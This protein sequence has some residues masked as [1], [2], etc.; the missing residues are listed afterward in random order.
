MVER[1]DFLKEPI[2]KFFRLFVGNEVRLKGA[3]IIKCTSFD[4]DENGN[5]TAIYATYDKDTKSGTEGA[6]RKVK[7]TI[8]FVNP[9]HA[10]KLPVAFLRTLLQK[11]TAK[12]WKRT[13]QTLMVLESTQT[14]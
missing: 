6:N 12:V 13:R 5:V 9:H 2:P 10:K 8:H 11:K 1:S 14:L 7:G 3:Y 4:E